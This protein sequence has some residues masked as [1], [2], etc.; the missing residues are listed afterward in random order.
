DHVVEGITGPR[1][2]VRIGKG[3]RIQELTC[4]KLVPMK[5]AFPVV[6]VSGMICPTSV[7]LVIQDIQITRTA[8]TSFGVTTIITTGGSWRVPVELRI[9]V[10]VRRK[11]EGILVKISVIPAIWRIL[12]H[13]KAHV[14][15]VVV[16]SGEYHLIRDF[17]RE[18]TEPGANCAQRGLHRSVAV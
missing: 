16:R 7:P 5:I 18:S 1:T 4:K 12:E 14:H 3:S 15:V 6:C 2:A 8:A 10:E 13:G 17:I 11:I 9:F